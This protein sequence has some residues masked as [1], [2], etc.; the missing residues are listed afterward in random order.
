MRKATKVF[1]V[2]FFYTAAYVFV[3]V[4][5]PIKPHKI[6]YV[7]TVCLIP[8]FDYS[9]KLC[10]GIKVYVDKQQFDIPSGFETD[11]ASIPKFYWGIIAPHHSALIMP[12]IF[13]DYLYRCKNNHNRKFADDVFFYFM[14]KN[15][16]SVYTSFKIYAAVRIFGGQNFKKGINCNADNK[17][18][19]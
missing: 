4:Y 9:F 1:V 14:R 17:S 19:R 11:L 16:L 6:H 12:S 10:Q 5:I 8:T 15:R 2:S 3:Y 7:G 18:R 13:H